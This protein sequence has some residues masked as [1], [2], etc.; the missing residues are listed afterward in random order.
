MNPKGVDKPSDMVTPL[1]RATTA[2]DIYHIIE[3]M[4]ATSF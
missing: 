3:Q 2:V 1:A 4:H